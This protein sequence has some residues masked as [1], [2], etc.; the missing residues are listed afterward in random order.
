[1]E[2]GSAAAGVSSSRADGYAGPGPR[3]RA[4]G[5]LSVGGASLIMGSIGVMVRYATVPASMLLVL[6][7]AVGGVVVG[8]LFARAGAYADLRRPGVPR[9][10]LV[11]GVIVSGNLLCYF[12]AI[13]YTDVAVA[14][15]TSYMAPVYVAM[16]SPLLLKQPTERVVYGALALSLVGMGAILLPG[17]VERGAHL[18][19]FGL[20]MGVVA[21]LLYGVFLI[22]AKGLRAHV[23]QYTIVLSECVV[24][25]VLVLPLGLYQT[26]G[27]GYHITMRDLVMAVMLGVFNT[28][29]SF[30]LFQHGLRYIR[31][32]HAS[33]LGYLEPVSAP[34]YALVFLSEV[35]SPWTVAGGA[36]IIA[37]GVL[38]VALGKADEEPLP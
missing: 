16:L 6:R 12:L 13:R 24:T 23:S 21:G 10:L 5:Y 4:I 28:A 7:M 22:L 29:V 14:I 2:S 33:I 32:Q 17:L 38:V 15:F 19:S 8:F 26:I 25:T 9:R 1:V 35:P 11:V 18:S 27:A 34:V 30:S 37:A 20:T 31:V 3:R 36:L